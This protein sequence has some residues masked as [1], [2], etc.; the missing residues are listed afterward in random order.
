MKQITKYAKGHRKNPTKAEAELK[1]KLLNWKI[2]FRS[3]RQFD[4]Y[5]VDFLIPDRRLVIEVDGGYH[6]NTVSYD[7]RR[8]SYLKS[9]G[10]QFIRISNQE[11]LNTNCEPLRQAIL[12]Y[13]IHDL[14]KLPLRLSYGKAKR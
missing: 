5:I 14:S 2:R 11:V 3:Q 13:T 4:Y 9:L 7:K 6:Q 12:Q 10:L 8:Q 1:R